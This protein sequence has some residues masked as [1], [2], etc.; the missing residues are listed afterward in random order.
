MLTRR[1][2]IVPC[3]ILLAMITAAIITVSAQ[4]QSVAPSAPWA[5]SITPYLWMPNINGTVNYSAY[6]G[7]GGPSVEVGP[8]NYLEALETALMIS[9]EVRKDR[10]FVFTD[11]IY[12]D[13]ANEES[14]GPISQLWRQC[15]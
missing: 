10:W 4:A 5:F 11:L 1:Q 15:C 14:A 9:G 7:G 2:R 6:P 12:L 13:F 3:M 8:D